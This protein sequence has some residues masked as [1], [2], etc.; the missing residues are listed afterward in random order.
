MSG[1][2]RLDELFFTGEGFTDQGQKFRTN[3]I[4]T[5]VLSLKF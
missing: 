1:G 3:I 4:N 2:D 5:E